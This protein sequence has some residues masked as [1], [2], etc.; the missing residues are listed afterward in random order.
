MDSDAYELR[1]PRPRMTAT[2]SVAGM[3]C[4]NCVRHVGEALREI[5]GVTDV[6]VD[7]AA[8]TAT[9]ESNEELDRAAAREA[10][11]DAGYAL[12]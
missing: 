12:T 7:L 10:L 3:T 11:E 8:G 9:V 5:P 1:R 6:R 2:L 4:D